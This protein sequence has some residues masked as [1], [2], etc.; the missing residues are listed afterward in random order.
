MCSTPPAAVRA[1][2]LAY[3]QKMN[4]W[5]PVEAETARTLER[6]MAT[7]FVDEAEVLRQISESRPRVQRHLDAATA[8]EPRTA[9]VRRIHATYIKAWRTLL[10]GYASI[11]TGFEHGDQGVEVP[12]SGGGHEGVDDLPLRVQVGVGGRRTPTHPPA[13]A[14]GQLTGRLRGAFDD[15]RDLVERHREHVVQDKREP[16]GR[17]ER[18][19]HNEQ[20][21]PHRVGQQRFVLGVPMYGL[22]WAV[23]G[24]RGRSRGGGGRGSGGGGGGNGG[25]AGSARATALQYAGVLALARSAGVVPVWDPSSGEVTFA[26][27]RGGVSHSVWYMDA[28]AISS[29]VTGS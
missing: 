21:Q 28:R 10:D 11:T 25:G 9:D 7:Q 19:E 20:R 2:T 29:G 22:D 15:R 12:L 1:D 13:G 16:L 3:L 5:A 14:A 6:I 27:V 8:Y 23:P 24:V 17:G 4:S 18:L 26:Y